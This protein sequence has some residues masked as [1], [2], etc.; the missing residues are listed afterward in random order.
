MRD[1]RYPVPPGYRSVG[2]LHAVTPKG[3]VYSTYSGR[4]MRLAM[5]TNG[6]LGVVIRTHDSDELKRREV[7]VLVCRAFRGAKPSERH[8]AS[9]LNG[10]KLDNREA[11]LAWETWE[12]N[13]NRT[14]EHGTD[15]KG[16]HNSRACVTPDQ[17]CWVREN[18][19]NLTHQQRA[20]R[21]GASRTSISRIANNQRFLEEEK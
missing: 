2:P 19:E 16:F 7:H 18:Q 6:R 21:L 1:A 4:N 8:I 9:H 20:D 17:A 10:N 5:G 11:N 13:R 14:Y 15:D 3:E 12:K